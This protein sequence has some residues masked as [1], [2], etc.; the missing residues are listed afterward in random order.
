VSLA[1]KGCR[2]EPIAQYLKA[3]G[4]LRLVSEQKDLGALGAW[5]GHHFELRSEL[6]RGALMRFLL[7]EYRPTSVVNAWNKDAGLTKGKLNEA[8]Q[9]VLARG[10]ERFSAYRQAWELA[11]SIVAELAESRGLSVAEVGKRLEKDKGLKREL[12]LRC[13]AELPDSAVAWLDAVAV[14]ASDGLEYPALLGTGGAMGRN[15]F[16]VTFARAL[17]EALPPAGGAPALVEQAL[18]GDESGSLVKLKIGQFDPGQA[19]GANSGPEGDAGALANPWDMVLAMEG[20]VMFASGAVRR[21]AWGNSRSAVPFT[22]GSSAVGYASKARDEEGRDS[23]EI[24]LPLWRRPASSAEVAR[25]IGEGR[26]TVGR[27]EDVETGLDFVR[28]VASLGV[29]RGISEFS[30][31]VVAER[32]GQSKLIVP[33]GRFQVREQPGVPLLDAVARWSS[34][35]RRQGKDLTGPVATALAALDHAEFLAATAGGAASFQ[36]VLFAL[37]RLEA[38]VWR[39]PALVGRG[40]GRRRRVVQAPVS[41]LPASAWLE[42]LYDG[43]PEAR[44]AAGL[45]SLR[46]EPLPKGQLQGPEVG[47]QA[48][49]DLASLMRPVAH[50]PK[51][52]LQWSLQPPRVR[53]LGLVPLARVLSEALVWR[54]LCSPGMRHA[55]HPH[56]VEVADGPVPL[57]GVDLAFKWGISSPMSDLD[58]LA[59]AGTDDSYLAYLLEAMLML[60]WTGFKAGSVPWAGANTERED[61]HSALALL[62]PFFQGLTPDS[63]RPRLLPAANWPH[64]LFAGRQRDVLAEA[65]RRLRWAG[66][67]P[68]LAH[69]E[70]VAQGTDGQRLAACMLVRTSRSELRRLLAAVAVADDKPLPEGASR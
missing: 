43:T 41:G 18:F 35:L 61:T 50:G 40:P 54:S 26:A 7:H 59:R 36:A 62:I 20:A 37:S 39:S 31:H 32:Y 4:L 19:G 65:L 12:V 21:L 68:L 55:A 33:V 8:V 67:V 46:D 23:K 17:Q 22:V 9:A 69:P 64:K 70:L 63:G 14:L 15:E 6:D 52:G 13:R 29:D 66:L 48:A 60:D 3:L 42:L 25:L 57:P 34:P 1:L 30:R 27:W 44:L 10:E 51:G 53:D 11:R 38:A 58:L 16:S 49:R 47:G 5:S 45:A 24:W 2:P 56:S 28:A